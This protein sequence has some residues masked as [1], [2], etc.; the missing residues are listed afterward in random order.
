MRIGRRFVGAK[1]QELTRFL[2]CSDARSSLCRFCFPFQGFAVLLIPPLEQARVAAVHAGPAIRIAREMGA[3]LRSLGLRCGLDDLRSPLSEAISVAGYMSFLQL[4]ADESSDPF[5]GLHV[6]ARMKITDAAG[7]GI[8]LS[9]CKNFRQAVEQTIRYECLSHDLG[10]SELIE[11]GTTAFYRWH[12]P[13]AHLRGYRHLV[14]LEMAFIRSVADWLAGLAVP[15]LSYE[16]NCPAPEGA[17]LGE[18]QRVLGAPVHFDAEHA[19]GSFPAALLDIPLPGADV[20]SLP[21]LKQIIEARLENHPRRGDEPK[22]I[23]ELRT[24]IHDNLHLGKISLAN[25]SAEMNIAPRTLQRRLAENDT[26]HS[27]LVDEVRRENA[28]QLVAQPNLSMTEVAYLLGFGE[29]STFN[30]AFKKWFGVSPTR[31]RN[32]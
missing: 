14:E 6:G 31:W 20:A 21:A 1:K 9:A 22:F 13:W 32:E 29:Q 10:R 26:S 30:H 23:G 15:V 16:L 19:A 28:K 18:Y 17:D 5:F 2:N 11:Q 27:Q 12:S 8:V 3:D 24:R 25:L 4:A 7:Y